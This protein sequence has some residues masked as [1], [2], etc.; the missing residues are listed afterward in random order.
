MAVLRPPVGAGLGFRRELIA[1]LQAGVPDAVRFFELAPENWAGLGG[2]S[3]RELRAF[4]ERFPFVCHGLSLSLGGPG[5]LDEAWLRRIK[6]FMREHG[7]TLYTEHLS[8][9]ADDSHLYDLLPIPQTEEA[10]HWVA[11]R[12]R[13]AQD[14][15][16]MRIGIENAS[17][18]VAPPGAEMGEAEFISAV[19]QE[20]DC[21]LHLDVNN[22][23]VNS[24]NFNFDA[25]NF[26][27]TL[28]LERTCYVHV[29]GHYVEP[30]G[31]V[32]DTH[33]AEVI[34]PVWALLAAAYERT[35]GEVPTCLE[36]DFN[37]P[38]LPVLVAEVAQIARLQA[39]AQRP[40]RRAA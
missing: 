40:M 16:E 3:A 9:C 20:A 4:T 18:Y 17:T 34:D 38:E 29:A 33:G 24:R 32:I 25:H 35:G 27:Q 5:P 21:L 13:R 37:L 22:I 19:V 23:Y 2:R 7:M 30:D 14:I 28:P 11:Q 6:V 15:L 39:A 1:P 26:L 10:V 36:R 8:W 12:I 31:L